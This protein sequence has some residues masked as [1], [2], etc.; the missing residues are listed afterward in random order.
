MPR[1]LLA[2]S[3]LAPS[4]ALACGGGQGLGDSVFG[5][6]IVAVFYGGPLFVAAALVATVYAISRASKAPTFPAPPRGP[7]AG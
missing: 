1:A 5:L 7:Q 4:L 3:L 2:L 6:I